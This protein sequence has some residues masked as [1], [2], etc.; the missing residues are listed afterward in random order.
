MIAN[1]EQQKATISKKDHLNCDYCRKPKHTKET[2][3]KLHG[4][5]TKGHREKWSNA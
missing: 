5:T 2:S 3:W 1:V 4:R